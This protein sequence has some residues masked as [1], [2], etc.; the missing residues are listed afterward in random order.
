MYP[1]AMEVTPPTRKE[2]AVNSPRS[3]NHPSAVYDVMMS[4]RIPNRTRKIA[5]ILSSTQKVVRLRT[6]EASQR[7]ALVL[8]PE[9][10]R[11]A[12]ADVLVDLVEP[13][14]RGSVFVV[15]RGH[16][17]RLRVL[18]VDQDPRD[19]EEEEACK[20]NTEHAGRKDDGRRGNRGGRHG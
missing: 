18:R 5:Q 16:E 12:A 13:R 3:K 20:E 11:R 4:T 2:T 8:G 10:R 14:H 7:H 1:D 19:E 15:D 17:T 6:H 9:E